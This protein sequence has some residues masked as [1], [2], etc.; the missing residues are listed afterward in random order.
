MQIIFEFRNPIFYYANSLNDR[1]REKVLRIFLTVF[2]GRK[3][4]HTLFEEVVTI[5]EAHREVS[6]ANRKRTQE[7]FDPLGF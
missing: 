1:F 7:Y 3:N 2:R 6:D 4:Y 5:L